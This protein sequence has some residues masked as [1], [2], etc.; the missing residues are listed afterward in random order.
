M[1]KGQYENNCKQ[2][3]QI[4]EISNKNPTKVDKAAALHNSLEADGLR[5]NSSAK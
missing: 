5:F 4:G 1:L 2:R 3:I